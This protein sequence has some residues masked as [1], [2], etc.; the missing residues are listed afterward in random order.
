MSS[1]S[2]IS[3]YII[4]SYFNVLRLPSLT[5]ILSIIIATLYLNL[6]YAFILDMTSHVSEGIRQLSL[7][8]GKT[9]RAKT[10]LSVFNSHLQEDPAGFIVYSTHGIVVGDTLLSKVYDLGTNRAVR[11]VLQHQLSLPDFL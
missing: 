10:I 5:H 1:V 6:K 8:A 3:M 7:T 9:E 4:T 2:L 11:T